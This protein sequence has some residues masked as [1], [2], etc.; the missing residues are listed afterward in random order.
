MPSIILPRRQFSQP[1]NAR[2]SDLALSNGCGA[3]LL[4]TDTGWS[5]SIN[6]L[7]ITGTVGSPTTVANTAGVTRSYSATA[8][9]LQDGGLLDPTGGYAWIM[10]C[11]L[12]SSGDNWGGLIARTQ[13]NATTAGWG[14]QK[15]NSGDISVYHGS[16]DRYSFGS[17]APLIDSLP[18]TLLGL[19]RADTNEV[20]LWRDG[21]L[22]W[23]GSLST[24]PDWWAGQGQIKLFSSRD[25]ATFVG[26]CSMAG[27]FT[28]RMD[29]GAASELSA[30]PW[31]LFGGKRVL[32]FDATASSGG[33]Q[34][35][36]GDATSTASA[37]ATLSV[38]VPLAG[39]GIVVATA[40]G[41]MS[42]GIPLAAAAQ[43]QPT[44]SGNLSTAGSV[45]LAGNATATASGTSTL[46]LTIPLSATA[47]AQALAAAGL[48]HGT[49]LAGGAAAQGSAG[50]A[51]TLNVSLAGNAIAQ[52][53]AT[54][55]LTATSA[56]SLAANAAA[57][58]AASGA[59][60]HAVP[61]AGAA[62][63]VAAA[64]AN[65]THIVPVAG[66]ASVAS[67]ATGGLDVSVSL[68]AAALVQAL[69]SAGLD[70]QGAG[71]AGNAGAQANA[72]GT[73]TLRIDLDGHGVA[74]AVAAGALASD[75]LIFA[76]TPGYT[77]DRAARSYT[78][79]HSARAWRIAA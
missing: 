45:S 12:T 23:G 11:A 72:D 47:V 69:A 53:A 31:Q 61:L 66:A 60:T 25:T 2:A 37:G 35:L 5:D 29:Q 67:L 16:T 32:Y 64:D 48:T 74:N 28:G 73:L 38:A 34:N 36:A 9:F 44:A 8:D 75:G 18:H 43:S 51:L 19:W 49:P 24:V 42:I 50:G 15:D 56:S 59:L 76:G 33:V 62:L 78:V 55:G 40:N 4:P 63:T 26:T 10:H 52:A 39:A 27:L 13:D 58:A 1:S 14:W 30:N 3:L 17:V 57:Q 65:I 71:L 46:S 21:D 6:M 79:S 68:Q 70:V 7:S 77:M 22:F 20:E 54:G 41:A